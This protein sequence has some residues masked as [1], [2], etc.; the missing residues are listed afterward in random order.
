MKITTTRFRLQ[1]LE[2]LYTQLDVE[3]LASCVQKK[4]DLEIYHEVTNFE[5]GEL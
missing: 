5:I 2:N 1:Y 4:D 3:H